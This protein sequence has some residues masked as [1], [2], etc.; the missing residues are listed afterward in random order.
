MKR[1]R[2]HRDSEA[3]PAHYRYR[4]R[5]S[6][7][8]DRPFGNHLAEQLR[9]GGEFNIGKFPLLLD[10]FNLRCP[11]DMS[12]DEVPPEAVGGSKRRFRINFRPGL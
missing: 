4:Q 5:D 1:L 9:P 2:Y 12:L 8:G 3:R 7:D 6:I 10:M 11:V